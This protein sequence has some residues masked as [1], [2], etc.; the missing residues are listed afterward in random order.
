[1]K[2]TRFNEAQPYNAINHHDV[3]ALRLQGFAKDGPS[4]FWT[5]LSHFLPGG[6]T[7]AEGSPLEKVYVVLAGQITVKADGQE[8]VLNPL[9]SCYIPPNQV[10][11]VRNDGNAVASMLVVMPYPEGKP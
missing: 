4:N 8:A 9:D 5:G 11:E 1:M 6:Y 7:V 2:V 10:R 3:H